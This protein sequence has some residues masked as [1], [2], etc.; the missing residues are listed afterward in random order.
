MNFFLWFGQLLLG[1][2]NCSMVSW[3]FRSLCFTPVLQVRTPRMNQKAFAR[4]WNQI[5]IYLIT[6]HTFFFV[7]HF[8]FW[9]R[10]C[11]VPFG[12]HGLGSLNWKWSAKSRPLPCSQRELKWLRCSVWNTPE[13]IHHIFV[14]YIAQY[15]SSSHNSK[16][17]A[18]TLPYSGVLD[19][20]S[21]LQLK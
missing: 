17:S 11:I 4:D 12:W 15:E 3:L 16:Y 1:F 18:E 19:P 7:F 14:E 5:N 6:E 10:L 9:V 20:P 13:I 2:C 21:S 8:L